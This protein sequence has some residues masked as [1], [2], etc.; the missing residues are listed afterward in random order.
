M[1]IAKRIRYYNKSEEENEKRINQQWILRRGFLAFLL[2]WH[3]KM[4]DCLFWVLSLIS[5]FV[6]SILATDIW[7]F[8]CIFFCLFIICFSEYVP[9]TI[10]S[11][12]DLF[13]S[14]DSYCRSRAIW[15]V[16]LFL[17]LEFIGK[18]L[19][20]RY[21]AESQGILAKN[22]G[23]IPTIHALTN[24]DFL[25]NSGDKQSPGN[26]TYRLKNKNKRREKEILG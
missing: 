1:N 22:F 17:Y 4:V 24:K 26:I 3:T 23:K 10:L 21:R 18:H 13:N 25:R 2:Q 14:F 5:D 9:I 11:Q 20:R 6:F 8:C 15:I 16:S 12:G 7:L 19:F